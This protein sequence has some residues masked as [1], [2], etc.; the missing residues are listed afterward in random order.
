MV[1]NCAQ[2]VKNVWNHTTTTA[3]RKK[4]DIWSLKMQKVSFILRHM[5]LRF[6]L[7]LFKPVEFRSTDK[8]LTMVWISMG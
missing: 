7:L 8:I 2:T 3:S 1:N 5:W 6:C 4:R